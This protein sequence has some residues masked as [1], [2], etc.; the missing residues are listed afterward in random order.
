MF[1]PTLILVLALAGA[2]PAAL[3][4]ATMEY[5][6]EGIESSTLLVTLPDSV[7]AQWS[8]RACPDCRYLALRVDETTEFRVG[9]NPVT[10]GTLRR[11]A[12][13]GP[14]LLGIYYDL[15]SKH[16]N[17]VILQT[18]LDAADSASKPRAR[19]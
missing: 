9:Q 5:P 1:R 2:A 3:G 13:R 8:V 14:T 4:Q 6:E 16:V 11:Y 7:P 10:L 19:R 12:A 17:R 18:E 15:R